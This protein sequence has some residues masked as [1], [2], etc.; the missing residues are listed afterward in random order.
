MATRTTGSLYLSA[1]ISR[2]LTTQKVNECHLFVWANFIPLLNEIERIPLGRFDGGDPWITYNNHYPFSEWA[3]IVHH[4]ASVSNSFGVREDREK[5]FIWLAKLS[6]RGMGGECVTRGI[7]RE[8][9]IIIRKFHWFRLFFFFGYIIAYELKQLPNLFV[10]IT[11][12]SIVHRIPRNAEPIM[13]LAE[14]GRCVDE[15]SHQNALEHRFHNEIIS[16]LKSKLESIA[17]FSIK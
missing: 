11:N 7:R 17:Y 5:P 2:S 16:I 14:F 9:L 1:S 8:W 15:E 4:G 6:T 13:E 10:Q 12:K 3:I